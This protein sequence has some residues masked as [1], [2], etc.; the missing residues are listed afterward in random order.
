MS[1][2]SSLEFGSG[3]KQDG[4]L[5]VKSQII[6]F[7]PP[8]CDLAALNGNEQTLEKERM[9]H[10]GSL[11]AYLK[12]QGYSLQPN[13]TPGLEDH[14][15]VAYPYESRIIAFPKHIMTPYPDEDIRWKPLILRRDIPITYFLAGLAHEATHLDRY[16]NNPDAR[17]VMD[18]MH[19]TD[20]LLKTVQNRADDI[21]DAEKIEYLREEVRIDVQA[22]FLL[23]DLGIDIA[24]ENYCTYAQR[25]FRNLVYEE[26]LQGRPSYQT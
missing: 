20:F 4:W 25:G 23:Q 10:A 1:D 18:R 6:P 14:F 12:Q 11:I 19:E 7:R 22:Y 26:L 3:P 2:P 24:P 13:A 8:N 5:R 17:K 15:G 16:F 9:R 21:P